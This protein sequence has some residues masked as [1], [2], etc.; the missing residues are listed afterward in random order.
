[1]VLGLDP[2]AAILA[3]W[4]LPD[5][6]NG[7]KRFGGIALEAAVGTV[8][9]VKP[10]SAFFERHGWRGLMVLAGLVRTARAAGL[11]VILDAKRG[12]IGP[13]NY[14][15]ASAYLGENAAVPVDALTVAAYL[16]IQAMGA[17]FDSA[18]R[19]G[20]GLF[21]VA[22]SSNPEGR[23]LQEA[24]QHNGKTVER[25][26]LEDLGKRNRLVAPGAV[27]PFGA[28]WAPAG[29]GGIGGAPAGVG[30]EP[31]GVGRAPADQ[32]GTDG[33]DQEGDAEALAA[34]GG[35]FLSPGIGAQG[36]GPADVARCFSACPERVLPSASRSLLAAG[37]S[38][39]SLREAVTAL[40]LA[41]SE[42][43][44]LPGNASD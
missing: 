5:N 40:N 32:V 17:F 7:L 41:L 4:A 36:Y 20:A 6:P 13:T 38:V 16:G 1:L 10:Q 35:L 31:A 44:A 18:A 23:F 26:I 33:Y 15:Y 8:G 34:M 28:V 14:A 12:D 30:G 25:A 21:V 37:P 24:H 29:V 2:S 27:G 9:M 42:A 11:L 3:S 43:L 19:G 22:R 39:P